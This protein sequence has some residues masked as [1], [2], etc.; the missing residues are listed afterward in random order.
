MNHEEFELAVEAANESLVRTIE[1]VNTLMEGCV[2]PD[3]LSELFNEVRLNN[4]R[5]LGQLLMENLRDSMEVDPAAF[6]DEGKAFWL[7]VGHQMGPDYIAKFCKVGAW[8]R[9]ADEFK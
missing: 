4:P 7:E 3:Y 5:A 6:T 2:N 8:M 1:H 9:R